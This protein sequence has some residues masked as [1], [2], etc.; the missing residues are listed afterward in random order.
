MLKAMGAAGGCAQVALA[1]TAGPSGGHLGVCS[2]PNSLRIRPF[3]Y[4]LRRSGQRSGASHDARGFRVRRCLERPP[5]SA[6]C[7]ASRARGPRQI[8][9]LVLR[10]IVDNLASRS[11]VTDGS[12]PIHMR[13]TRRSFRLCVRASCRARAHESVAEPQAVADLLKFAF[14]MGDKTLASGVDLV[15]AASIVTLVSTGVVTMKM[16]FARRPLPANRHRRDGL[17]RVNQG[18]LLAVDEPRDGRRPSLRTVAVGRTRYA[19]DAQRARSA[20]VPSFDVHV[21][22]PR[23]CGRSDCR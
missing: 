18:R 14:P 9:R 10:P 17:L 11:F 22:R 4:C 20:A 19:R 1:L 7:I 21:G 13:F 6:R 23:M 8:S 5:R 16:R 3:T 12:A 15:P 2:R